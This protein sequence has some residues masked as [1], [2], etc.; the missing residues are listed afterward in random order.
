VIH[1]GSAAYNT[2]LRERDTVVCLNNVAIQSL[3]RAQVDVLLRGNP[4]DKL[5]IKAIAASDKTEYEVV[6]A[7]TTFGKPKVEGKLLQTIS[8]ISAC[9]L[10]PASHLSPTLWNSLQLLPLRQ[11]AL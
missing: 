2:N 7:L 1:Y 11:A 5:T 3:S 6:L 10:L 4:G 9:H 8:P